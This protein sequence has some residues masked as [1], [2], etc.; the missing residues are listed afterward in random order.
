M[1]NFMKQSIIF[2]LVFTLMLFS[3][4]S[5]RGNADSSD[6]EE[7]ININTAS[8]TE[9]QKLPRI[10]EKVAQSI[11]DFRA[12]NGKFKRI[13]DIMKVK[14]IGESIFDQIKDRITV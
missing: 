9:L 3:L 11:I 5:L 2:T 12:K 10:G 7:K 8:S 13:E 4:F 14:G 6:A 1:K